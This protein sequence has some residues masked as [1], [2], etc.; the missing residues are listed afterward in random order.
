MFAIPA[1]CS[2]PIKIKRCHLQGMLPVWLSK[3]S[4][5]VEP[6]ACQDVIPLSMVLD[7]K[8]CVIIYSLHF[9]INFL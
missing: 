2:N 7:A 6:E 9:D 3:D 4:A 5:K 8:K 1:A